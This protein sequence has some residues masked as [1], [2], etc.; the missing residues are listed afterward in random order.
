[1]DNIPK[2]GAFFIEP[3]YGG[4]SLQ[5][6]HTE[7]QTPMD[8]SYMWPQVRHWN[9]T[10]G[11]H[12]DAQSL[13]T[14]V[15][16]HSVVWVLKQGRSEPLLRV[17]STQCSKGPDAWTSPT[18]NGFLWAKTRGCWKS[19]SSDGFWFCSEVLGP[20]G[21]ITHPSQ[22]KVAER[23]LMVRRL[24][25]KTPGTPKWGM[26]YVVRR[27]R[28]P[29]KPTKWQVLKNSYWKWLCTRRSIKTTKEQ[30]SVN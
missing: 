27:H 23:K 5:W 10:W 21:H 22:K 19:K 30:T 17:L 14:M 11:R 20:T 16:W 15:L 2:S 18:R 1:M 4:V 7:Q 8:H 3:G 24:S 13:W 26:D 29:G 9:K 6:A 25:S 28:R 12:V